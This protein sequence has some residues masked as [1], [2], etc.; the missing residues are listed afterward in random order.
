MLENVQENRSRGQSPV[1]KAILVAVLIG[2]L[3]LPLGM[4]M[5]LIHEREATRKAA[6]REVSEKWGAQQTVG[7]PVLLVPYLIRAV[8]ANGKSQIVT[9][10]ATVLPRSLEI[11]GELTPE[12]RYRG[13]FEVPLYT[14]ELRVAGTFAPEE[15]SEL[16]I[17]ATD[18]LWG[19]AVLSVGIP[20]P[21]GIRQSVTLGWDGTELGFEPGAG[22]GSLFPSGIHVG[23]GDL[24]S[25]SGELVP[26]A[27]QFALTLNGSR[28][29]A[30]IPA[31]RDTRLRLASAWPSP[32]FTG[33]FLPDSRTVTAD[34][35]SAEW[36]L[37]YLGRSYPQRWKA[38]EV[39][40]GVVHAS[41]AGVDLVLPV[42]TYL[43]SMRSAKYGVLFLI[44]TFGAYYLFEILGRSRIHPFQ[45]L[46]VGAALV[47]FYVLLLSLSEHVRFDL[48]YGLAAAATLGL[49]LGYSRFILGGAGRLAGLGAGLVG[50][51]LFL[52]VLLQLEDL[53]LLLGSIGLFLALASVMWVTRRV[54]WYALQNELE[55]EHTSLD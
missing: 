17:P 41:A 11:E 45:Y 16:S 19:D 46:L 5:A 10:H 36:Q 37:F 22:T 30:F 35:F 14:V 44:A 15:I 50:L 43:K 42:D 32:S 25:A 54:D 52:Y 2:L 28:H 40:P 18:I 7:G 1:L 51:Y 55:R 27:F 24:R 9:A 48:A 33:A 26:H 6:E 3:L 29:I 47:V 8:D 38:G 4:V 20:D 53:A 49:I 21:R 31:G 12:I 34:G 23:I 39:D 13:I